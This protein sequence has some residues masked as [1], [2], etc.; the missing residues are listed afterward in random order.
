MRGS[1][2]SW[3]IVYKL[4]VILCLFPILQVICSF[5]ILHFLRVILISCHSYFLH[6]HTMSKKPD[7]MMSGALRDD[8]EI[9]E[10]ETQMFQAVLDDGTQASD[11]ERHLILFASTKS[12]PEG[13]SIKI[14]TKANKE[15]NEMDKSASRASLELLS[16]KFRPLLEDPVSRQRLVNLISKSNDFYKSSPG[17]SASPVSQDGLQSSRISKDD[18]LQGRKKLA[19]PTGKIK[20][21]HLPKHF[22]EGSTQKPGTKSS[23]RLDTCLERDTYQGDYHFHLPSAGV[24]SKDPA[25]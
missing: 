20:S 6:T 25:A 13:R 23:W 5:P 1:D 12:T 21:V 2:P 7:Y 14:T 17:G 24:K 8:E 16:Q 9:R 11:D 15:F 4:P 18:L 10:A 22:H 19:N 3:P